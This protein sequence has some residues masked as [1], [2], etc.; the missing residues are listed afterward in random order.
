MPSIKQQRRRIS[1][2]VRRVVDQTIPLKIERA[3]TAI[4]IVVGNKALE[5]TPVEFSLLVNSQDRQTMAIPGGYRVSVVYTQNYAAALHNRDDWKPR[6]PDQK[7]GPAWN[8]KARPEFLAH[9]AELTRTTQRQI[10]RGELR[11]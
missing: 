1:Q 6:P 8:P 4:G 5:F 9:G 2:N 10:I 11:L 3:L 7:E